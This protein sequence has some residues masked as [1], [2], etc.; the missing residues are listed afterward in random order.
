[1]SPRPGLSQ[2]LI[3]CRPGCLTL[4]PAVAARVAGTTDYKATAHRLIMSS[5]FPSRPGVPVT[6]SAGN[7]KRSRAI[8]NKIHSGMFLIKQSRIQHFLGV[9]TKMERDRQPASPFQS[10]TSVFNQEDW[11]KNNAWTSQYWCVC[12]LS[13]YALSL[14]KHLYMC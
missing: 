2:Q 12:Y 14:T 8:D 7:F 5:G 11:S 3:S 13:F 6:A 9:R 4:C 1:M 10:C